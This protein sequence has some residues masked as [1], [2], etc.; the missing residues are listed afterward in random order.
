MKNTS[1]QPVVIAENTSFI[2]FGEIITDEGGEQIIEK[3]KVSVH[4]QDPR[5]K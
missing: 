5:I 4:T 2:E 3:R 1:P